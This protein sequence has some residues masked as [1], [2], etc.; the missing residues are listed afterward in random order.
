MDRYR[1]PHT[2]GRRGSTKAVKQVSRASVRRGWCIA[3]EKHSELPYIV[4]GTSR[5]VR[6]PHLRV[7]Q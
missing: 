3:L 5:L 6:V 7:V 1:V 2:L 4:S